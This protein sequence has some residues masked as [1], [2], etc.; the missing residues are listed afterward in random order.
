MLWQW[1]LV[2]APSPCPPFTVSRTA[3]CGHVTH[4]GFRLAEV[5]MCFPELKQPRWAG[6]RAAKWQTSKLVGA[7]SPM[8]SRPLRPSQC[9]RLPDTWL[10]PPTGDSPYIVFKATVIFLSCSFCAC[11]A[12]ELNLISV[13]LL[14]TVL[15]NVVVLPQLTKNNEDLSLEPGMG[16]LPFIT[17]G[18]VAELNNARPVEG[19]GRGKWLLGRQLTGAA[20]KVE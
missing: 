3:H 12:T 17:W 20:N 13:S 4:K 16:R 5:Q 11:Y 14:K 6:D 1:L 15:A 10:L 18:R 8:P 9:P 2:A 19:G 7:S